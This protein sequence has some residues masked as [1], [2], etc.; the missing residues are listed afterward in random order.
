[1]RTRSRPDHRPLV[2]FRGANEVCDDLVARAT[3][4]ECDESSTV[5]DG[6]PDV[7][8]R[9]CRSARPIDGDHLRHATGTLTPLS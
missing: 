5:D 8:S 7:L 2:V 3:V 9:A 6:G 4:V 1:M